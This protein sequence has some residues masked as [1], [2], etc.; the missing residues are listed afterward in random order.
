MGM[1]I[2]WL[3]EG[4]VL[5]VHALGDVATEHIQTMAQ[6][7]ATLIDDQTDAPLIHMLVDLSELSSYPNNMRQ[8]AQAI[9]PLFRHKRLGWV[10]DYGGGQSEAFVR[11]TTAQ[12]YRVRFRMFD[13]AKAA[14][15]FLNSV[16]TT[17]PPLQASQD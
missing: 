9:E 15:E 11:S 1:A 16:D 4:R 12:M 3:V 2:D 5:Q 7:A 14:L 10:I 13:T 17:L 8:V 6:Q